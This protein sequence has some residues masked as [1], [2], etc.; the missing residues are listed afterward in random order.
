VST[1]TQYIS[2]EPD[3]SAPLGRSP[4]GVHLY[5]DPDAMLSRRPRPEL[6]SSARWPNQFYIDRVGG[7]EDF[8]PRKIYLPKTL[9]RALPNDWR[10]TALVHLWFRELGRTLLSGVTK[11]PKFRNIHRSGLSERLQSVPLTRGRLGGGSLL[12]TQ[13][14]RAA[15][16]SPIC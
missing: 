7:I 8:D 9:K 5:A 3:S 14:H 4:V 2:P 15:R 1:R 6:E 13:H 11:L 16:T 12:A 10:D